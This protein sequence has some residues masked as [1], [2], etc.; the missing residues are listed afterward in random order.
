VCGSFS[1]LAELRELN[2]RRELEK[3][4]A[5]PLAL[6]VN[7]LVTNVVKHVGP[8]CGVS[9]RSQGNALKLTVSDK[10]PGPCKD[11]MQLGLGSRIIDAFSTQLGA[12]VE[13]K[14]HAMG[15]TTELTV[16]LPTP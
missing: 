8:P 9:L 14:R 11:R 12:S 7:E 10:G 2:E 1:E 15:Y 5:I 3:A 13:T 4:M 6:I 16:P